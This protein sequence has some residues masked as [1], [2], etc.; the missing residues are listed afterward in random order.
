MAFSDLYENIDF[1]FDRERGFF[2]VTA[3]TTRYSGYV[4]DQAELEKARAAW[5]RA[6]GALYDGDAVPT[7]VEEWS[8]G[9][10]DKIVA[11]AVGKENGIVVTAVTTVPPNGIGQGDGDE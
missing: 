1:D 3:D 9:F 5:D 10:F 7:D 8:R 4:E 2:R 6:G 11:A